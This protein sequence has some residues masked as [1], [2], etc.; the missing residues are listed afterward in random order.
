MSAKSP[1]RSIPGNG[2]GCQM[3]VSIWE[4][5]SLAS[6]VSGAINA[7]V[8]AFRGS[9]VPLTKDRTEFSAQAPICAGFFIKFSMRLLEINW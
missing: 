2:F 5:F 8:D 6:P 9:T 7:P 4:I 3:M 1:E